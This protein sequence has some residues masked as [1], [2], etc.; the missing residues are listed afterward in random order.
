VA[1]GEAVA[2]RRHLRVA[3]DRGLAA[4]PWHAAQARRTLEGVA[5]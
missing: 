2:G 5:R 4:W 1:A 3:L